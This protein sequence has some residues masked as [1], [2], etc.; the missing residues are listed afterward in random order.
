MNQNNQFSQSNQFNQTPQFQNQNFNNNQFQNSNNNMNSNINQTPNN[1]QYQNFN[2]YQNSQQNYQ[3]EP[4][5]TNLC[6]FKNPLFFQNNTNLI[7][8]Y[9]FS[10]N[11]W[12]D[13]KNQNNQ[14]FPIFY[15]ATELPDSSF[16]ISG[17]DINGTPTNRVFHFLNLNFIQ[18]DNMLVAR[19]AHT[20][21]YHKG[22]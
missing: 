16:L 7:H 6:Y 12:C 11:M 21:I 8:F 1:N 5:Y 9:D 14:F 2:Q 18:K 19:R 10:R 20:A 3:N 22:N 13:V 15:R 17:G 4:W